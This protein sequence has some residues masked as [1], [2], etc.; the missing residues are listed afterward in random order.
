MVN[1]VVKVGG[2]VIDFRQDPGGFH[3]RLEGGG[4]QVGVRIESA[5]WQTLTEENKAQFEKGKMA[6]A[7]GIL[8]LTGEGELFVVLGIIPTPAATSTPTP[9]PPSTPAPGPSPAPSPP[10]PEQEKT[11]FTVKTPANTPD[12][13]TIYMEWFYGA[14]SDFDIIWSNIE[15]MIAMEQVSP[16]TWTSEIVLSSEGHITGAE[17]FYYRY[18]RDTWGYPAAEEFTPDSENAYRKVSIKE[19]TGKTITDTVGKWRWFPHPDDPPLPIP[20]SSAQTTTIKPRIQDE[21]LRRGVGLQ[22]FW[23]GSYGDVL[24]APTHA[25]I[26]ADY[27]DSIAVYAP[28]WTYQQIEPTPIIVG[29]SFYPL[30]DVE[31]HLPK[32][33]EDGFNILICVQFGQY[34]ED[35]SLY[36]GSPFDKTRS[37]EWWD[38]WYEEVERVTLYTAD[39]AEKHGV[40][41]LAPFGGLLV[42][43]NKAPDAEKRFS[44]IIDKIRQRYS[45]EI[46]SE[47]VIGLK[48]PQWQEALPL[49]AEIPAYGKT[50]FIALGLVAALAE[51]SNPTQEELNSNAARLFKNKLEPLYKNYNKP[52]V[53]V[54]SMYGSYEGVLQGKEYGEQETWLWAPAHP[55]V[56]FSGWEQAMAHEAVMTAVADAEYIIGIY[57][58]GY[59]L[60]EFPRHIGSDIRGKPAEQLIAGWYKRFLE[61]GK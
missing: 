58:F 39:L 17:Y 42:A 14:E 57:P 53:I 18:S 61:E 19:S 27:A 2:T 50:D 59:H 33:R 51:S 56:V 41:M 35:P 55:D 34:A 29:S 1:Q 52:I 5:T 11:T 7:E 54:Q 10:Q 40:E 20:T 49:P 23:N 21:K 8:V 38:A 13:S 16:N 37:Q 30:E 12:Y 43:W 9:V 24:T 47:Q 60:E 36:D 28:I 15:Y 45:G 4:G 44:E 3:L 26:K 32:L 48:P 25:D 6:T 46:G 31:K 22:D